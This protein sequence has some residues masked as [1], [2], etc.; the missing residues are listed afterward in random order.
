VWGCLLLA[1]SRLGEE[2][3]D[4]WGCFYHQLHQ[5]PLG[6]QTQLLNGTT[7]SVWFAT[8]GSLEQIEAWEQNEIAPPLNK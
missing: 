2:H 3:Q 4:T 1:A 5:L 7:E 6:V 8:C